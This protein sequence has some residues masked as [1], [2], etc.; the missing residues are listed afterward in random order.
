MEHGGSIMEAPWDFR[1]TSEFLWDFRDAYMGLPVPMLPP[2]H[3][4]GDPMR[5]R[6]PYHGASVVFPWELRLIRSALA[7]MDTALETHWRPYKYR[8]RGIITSKR[9]L[10]IYYLHSRLKYRG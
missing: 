8:V 2:W 9:E 1:G 6:I 4:Y 7:P 10:L 3:S 5:L